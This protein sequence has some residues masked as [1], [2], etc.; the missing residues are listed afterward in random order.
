MLHTFSRTEHYRQTVQSLPKLEC[1]TP[2]AI[3]SYINTLYSTYPA[4]IRAF[5]ARLAGLWSNW[6]ACDDGMC[7]L[8]AS[9]ESRPPPA[10]AS[11]DM[12]L[13]NRLLTDPGDILELALNGDRTEALRS[14]ILLYGLRGVLPT[15]SSDS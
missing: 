4:L 7:G 2:P 8:L 12:E 1:S 9:G 14:V 5:S 13:K 15:R 3:K 6:N 10:P 11:M